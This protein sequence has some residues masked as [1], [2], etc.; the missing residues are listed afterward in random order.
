M[1]K[2]SAGIL[3]YRRTAAGAEVFLVHPGGPFWAGKDE[4]AWSIPKGEFTDAEDPLAAAC[5]EFREETGLDISG[6]LRPLT[7]V[8]QAGGKV[9]HAWAVEGEADAGAIRSNTF[10][11]EWPRGS[12]IQREFPEVDR[13]AWFSLE[14]AKRKIH[15]GQQAILDEL[16]RLLGGAEGM[17][18]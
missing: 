10:R 9:V 15:K 4:H 7:P 12:G 3:L 8:K 5:R 13:A 17:P 1:A 16:T 2:I 18:R 11:M 6:D 14:T